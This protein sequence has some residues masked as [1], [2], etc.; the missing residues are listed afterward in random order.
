VAGLA[1]GSGFIGRTAFD[2]PEERSGSATETVIRAVR[3]RNLP[4]FYRKSSLHTIAY[5]V[6]GL[7][8]CSWLLPETAPQAVGRQA[9]AYLRQQVAS[10]SLVGWYEKDWTPAAKSQ[11]LTGVAQMAVVWLREAARTTSS[12]Q[13]ASCIDAADRAIDIVC[14][15][16]RT[17]HRRND[18]VGAVGGSE[19]PWGLYLPFRYPSW[20]AKFVADA[21]TLRLMSEGAATAID[22]RIGWG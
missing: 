11:C 6:Q 10:G 15:A 20:A 3:D 12:D 13:R 5:T 14:D 8:E 18:V 1:D 7:L 4:S 16:Q 22:Q 2:P 17:R 21:L 9:S 19:P